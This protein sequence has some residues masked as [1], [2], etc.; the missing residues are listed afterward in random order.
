MVL[1][2]DNGTQGDGTADYTIY[3]DDITQ[4]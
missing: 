3:L 1:I 4:N 2:M